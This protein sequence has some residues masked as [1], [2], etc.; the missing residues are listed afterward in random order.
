MRLEQEARV[1]RGK[2]LSS[3]TLATA[4]FDSPH[5]EGRTTQVR[6]AGAAV[7][8]GAVGAAHRPGTPDTGCEQ[9]GC[10][11]RRRP[12]G[13]LSRQPDPIGRGPG[14]DHRGAQ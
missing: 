10:A 11:G 8:M 4:A 13:R 6:D 5:Q 14:V 3:L 7:D 9:P 2:A 12:G 1:L